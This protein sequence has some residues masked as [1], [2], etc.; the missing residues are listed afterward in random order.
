MKKKNT[1]LIITTSI[2]SVVLVVSAVCAGVFFGKNAETMKS[3]FSN[4]GQNFTLSSV[5]EA[6]KAEAVENAISDTFNVA[7]ANMAEAVNEAYRIAEDDKNKA[8]ASAEQDKND[9][10]N[11]AAQEKAQIIEESNK[12]LADAQIEKEQAVSDAY[13]NGYNSKLPN[14]FEV[15]TYDDL[16]GLSITN[17]NQWTQIFNAPE[18]EPIVEGEYLEYVA[19]K[20]YGGNCGDCG[21]LVTD[22]D[23]EMTWSDYADIYSQGE[24][25]MKITDE[26]LI[27]LVNTLIDEGKCYTLTCLSSGVYGEGTYVPLLSNKSLSEIRSGN[28]GKEIGIFIKNGGDVYTTYSVSFGYGGSYANVFE[29]NDTVRYVADYQV[30]DENVGLGDIFTKTF[31]K[32][33]QPIYK[34]SAKSK[35]YLINLALPSDNYFTFC[36]R[37]DCYFYKNF[38][39]EI[40]GKSY[41]NYACANDNLATKK[42]NSYYYTEGDSNPQLYMYYKV[43]STAYL[44]EGTLNRG[45]DYLDFMRSGEYTHSNG[46]VFMIPNRTIFDYYSGESLTGGLTM[47]VFFPEEIETFE[48]ISITNA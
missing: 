3:V 47:L 36:D 26:N 18:Y 17:E 35:G 4:S 7:N 44:Q 41:C 2:L 19:L 1:A 20:N 34:N 12:A 45:A 6:E 31:Y 22:Y 11:A 14:V 43:A 48:I 30:V 16:N 40:N 28:G 46:L 24:T 10:L 5:A 8:L 33:Y 29:F 42:W 23:V 13:V 37:G 9:A 27:N 39:F 38:N 21:P 25:S 32:E 15:E